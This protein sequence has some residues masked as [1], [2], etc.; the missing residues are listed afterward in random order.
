[1]A[2]VSRLRTVSRL[3][4]RK[5]PNRSTVASVEG[6]EKSS[7]RLN[8]GQRTGE[9]ALGELWKCIEGPIQ[10]LGDWCSVHPW[11]APTPGCKEV[12]VN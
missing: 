10:C 7:R 8:A 6:T 1:M 4:L 9:D 2:S 5:G 3:Q 11:E 12:M